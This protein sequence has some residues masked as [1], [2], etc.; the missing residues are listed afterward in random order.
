M[1][2]RQAVVLFAI[3]ATIR[4]VWGVWIH[5][6]GNFVTS[7]MWVYDQNAIHFWRQP[8]TL[9]DTYIPAGY[10]ALLAAVYAVAGSARMSAVA[11]LQ[12][13]LGA[14]TC[15]LM[16]GITRLATGSARLGLCAGLVLAGY[17]PLVFYA[18]FLLTEVPFAF[19]VAFGAWLLLRG[20]LS[21]R[22]ATAAGVCFGAATCVR[23]NLLFFFPLVPIYAWAL[24]RPA[25][26]RA[27]AL[28]LAIGL[29]ALSI[30]ALPCIRNSRIAG[31]PV[32]IATN[33]GL[34]FFLSQE[35]V[36]GARWREGTFV[37]GIFPIYNL[38]HFSNVYWSS[39]ALYDEHA[40]YEL[41]W[42]GLRQHPQRLLRWL[43]NLRDAIGL[44]RQDYWPGWPGR[45][46]ALV[47]FAR[48]FVPALVAP[49]IFYLVRRRKRIGA[50]LLLVALLP[51]STVIPMMVFLGDPRLRVPFDPFV[52][53]LAL[54]GYADLMGM[55][56]RRASTSSARDRPLVAS[57]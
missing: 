21:G 45:H 9:W 23:P 42:R 49:A 39:N 33:G 6:P 24:C 40:F 43:D 20:G 55:L 17:V 25:R 32:G 18:G 1:S 37:H 31:R 48:G 54:G 35:P 4:L 41:G 56:L 29:G 8:R 3:A 22:Y 14:A 57:S 15:V 10:P 19:L 53:A 47:A 11:V 50:P 12:A 2:R 36:S 27:V 46:A 5:P 16:A 44:G 34:N 51:L 38:L 52:L 28:T 13:I 26:V 30:I 7:D